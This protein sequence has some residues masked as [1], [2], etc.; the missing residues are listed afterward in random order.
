MMMLEWEGKALLRHAG[1][2]VPDG[3]V[4]QRGSQVTPFDDPVAVKAQVRSGGRGK[5]G[6]VLRAA[7]LDAARLAVDELMVLRFAGEVPESVLIESWQAIARELY[8]S[9][10]VDGAAEGYALLY[11]PQGGVDIEAGQAP[12]RYNIGPANNFRAWRFRAAIEAV[13]ADVSVRERVVTLGERLVRLAAARD[14]TTI[15]INPLAMLQDGALMALD[16]KVVRDDWAHFRQ[17]DI[18][19]LQ[20]AEKRRQPPLVRDCMDMQHMYVPLGGDVALISGGAGMTMGVMDM[21][22]DL[23]GAPACFLDCS[24]GPA[25]TRGYRPAFAMLDADPTVKVILVSVFGGG[26]HM[27]RVAAA[28][29]DIL[30]VRTSTKPVVFRLDGTH[31]D[32]VDGILAD[33]GARNHA[34]LEA[35]VTEAVRLAKEAA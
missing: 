34:S 21:I 29:R 4:L 3:Q 33:V 31:V 15:E 6:G 25:S 10:V 27:D 8:L 22:K 18:A 23:G 11:A 32:Q 9:V 2:A 30:P 28:M 20:E 1:V 12:L 7:T 13:E 26:T 14:C 5:S 35:A 19:A 17:Q 24:P 16:A